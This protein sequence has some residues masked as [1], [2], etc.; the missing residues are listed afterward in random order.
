MV[1]LIIVIALIAILASVLIP[2]FANLINKANDSAYQQERTNQMIKDEIEKID[3]GKVYMSWEDL[4]EAI[5]EALKDQS[6]DK[7]L[8]DKIIAIIGGLGKTSTGLTNEQLT[9]ILDAIANKKFSDTQVKVIL[10]G[11]KDDEDDEKPVLTEQQIADIL[12]KLPQ[13]GITEDDLK[14]AIT[15]VL[16]EQSSAINAAVQ[17]ILDKLPA[18]LTEDKIREI[19]EGIL[20]KFK[21]AAVEVTQ[22]NYTTI[23]TQDG[24]YVLSGDI[25]HVSAPFIIPEGVTVTLDLNGHNISCEFDQEDLDYAYNHGDDS[26]FTGSVSTVWN[27]GT[28]TLKG[29]G[30]VGGPGGWFGIYNQ[31]ALTLDGPTVEGGVIVFK[32][33][34]VTVPFSALGQSSSATITAEGYEYS[35]NNKHVYSRP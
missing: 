1:E 22:S 16:G 34:G 2:T 33:Y 12:A 27:K 32:D 35:G 5:A 18:P 26:E 9:K 23:F 11:I 28:L 6:T 13:V 17:A 25:L 8:A 19:V 21:P 7:N 29:T 3:Q 20:E 4:E 31:G 24:N 14:A 10:E 15:A 30:K